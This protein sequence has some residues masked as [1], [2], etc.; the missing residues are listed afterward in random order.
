MDTTHANTESGAQIKTDAV[1]AQ[2]TAKAVSYAV[3]S[4]S[5]SRSRQSNAADVESV[6]ARSKKNLEQL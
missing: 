6:K 1:I 4:R 2:W 3:I 5:R